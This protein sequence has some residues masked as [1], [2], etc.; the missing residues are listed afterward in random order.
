MPEV[1][2]YPPIETH[3]VGHGAGF[4]ALT[5]SGVRIQGNA[6]LADGGREADPWFRVRSTRPNI[7]CNIATGA[8]KELYAPS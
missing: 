5:E 6:I 7:I 8:S 4:V 1:V 3:I 2:L